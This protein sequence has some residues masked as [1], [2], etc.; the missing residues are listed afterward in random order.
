MGSLMLSP[1]VFLVS[2][3]LLTEQ[4]LNPFTMPRTDMKLSKIIKALSSDSFF[5]LREYENGGLATRKARNTRHSPCR[6]GTAWRSDLVGE[7]ALLWSNTRCVEA[8]WS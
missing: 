1:N 7:E 4:L 8:V 6:E 3:S 5:V 2:S